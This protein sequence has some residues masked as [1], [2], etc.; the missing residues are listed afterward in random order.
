M[1]LDKMRSQSKHWTCPARLESWRLENTSGRS[2]V[3]PHLHRFSGTGKD[4]ADGS[5][6]SFSLAGK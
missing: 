1:P 2:Y 5:R 3:P 4:D 6:P